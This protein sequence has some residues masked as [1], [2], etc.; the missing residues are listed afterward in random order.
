MLNFQN[1]LEYYNDPYKIDIPTNTMCYRNTYN[2]KFDGFWFNVIK[3]ILRLL[4]K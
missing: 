2:V 3:K 1:L 4:N